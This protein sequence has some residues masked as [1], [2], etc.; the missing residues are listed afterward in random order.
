MPMRKLRHATSRFWGGD[1][2]VF[3]T[4][5][6]WANYV[7]FWK[8]KM[9]AMIM[10]AALVGSAQADEIEVVVEDG[11][12]TE[13]S[14]EYTGFA[15]PDL[16]ELFSW[17]TDGYAHVY[18]AA[19]NKLCV[20]FQLDG[21]ADYHLYCV[22]VTGSDPVNSGRT[23][24]STNKGAVAISVDI[25]NPF[26]AGVTTGVGSPGSTASSCST[27]CADDSTCHVTCTSGG[28]TANCNPSASCSC[29]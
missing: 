20:E 14:V 12:S 9:N 11:G 24:V 3:W 16:P 29:L 28:C 19:T 7:Q 2:V 5:M 27:L 25:K 13:V 6:W 8:M 15:D 17:G 18:E 22:E 10:L 23:W 4:G 21:H 26:T 1:V